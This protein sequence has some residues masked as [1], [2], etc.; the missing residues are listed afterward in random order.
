MEEFLPKTF[1]GEL[2]R[3]EMSRRSTQEVRV[4]P[5][6]IADKFSI[7]SDSQE[8]VSADRSD[9]RCQI[10]AGLAAFEQ[11]HLADSDG[12]CSP[13]R[14]CSFMSALQRILPIAD[15]TGLTSNDPSQVRR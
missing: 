12:R 14:T 6:C 1:Y 5:P 8:S 10:N 7:D 4:H 2:Q 11:K 15:W 13:G 3:Q 9:S